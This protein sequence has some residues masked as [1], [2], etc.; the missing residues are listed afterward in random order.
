[1]GMKAGN[2]KRARRQLDETVTMQYSTLDKAEI[3]FSFSSLKLR[4]NEL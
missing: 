3:L 2:N 4:Q 1:M